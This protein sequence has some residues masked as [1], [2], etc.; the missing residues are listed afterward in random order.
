MRFSTKSKGLNAVMGT[1]LALVLV[2]ALLVRYRMSVLESVV[3]IIGVLLSVVGLVTLITFLKGK[4]RGTNT[5][6]ISLIELI[7]GVVIAIFASSFIKVGFV[8]IGVV[9]LILGIIQFVDY[10]QFRTGVFSLI[11][12]IL[13]VIVGSLLIAVPW[14]GGDIANV[15]ALTVGIISIVVGVNS[16]FIE[17]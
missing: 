2:G 5:L 4:T 3:F 13:R 7:F 10:I 16:L 11:F 6:V 1:A 15:F 9:I 17:V 14:T 8:L 12:A